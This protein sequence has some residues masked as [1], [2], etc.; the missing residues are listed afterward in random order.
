MSVP[1]ARAPA[2]PPG[3]QSAGS[4]PSSNVMWA[5]SGVA[6]DGHVEPPAVAAAHAAV[7]A[8]HHHLAQGHPRPGAEVIRSDVR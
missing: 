5:S 8:E 6:V 1:T 3:P 2:V 4:A 7:A